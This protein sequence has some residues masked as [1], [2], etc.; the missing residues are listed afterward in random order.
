MQLSRERITQA[1][2]ELL[3][4][5]GLA[6]VSMRRVASS[7]GVAPGALYWHI[8]NKQ[9]LLA[10]LAEHIVRPLMSDPVAD[11]AE[12]S[13]ALREAVLG[14][15][16]GAEVL[17]AAVSQPDAE[18]CAQLSELFI[19]SVR[20]YSGEGSSSSEMRA[21]ALGL[22][23]LTLGDAAVHQASTQLAEAT[24][25]VSDT[26]ED[27]SAQMHAAAVKFLLDGLALHS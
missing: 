12:L 13:R 9:E 4:G 10:S 19:A 20:E 22:L 7:L 17:V 1:A 5:Y 26:Y 18:V 27:D 21:V 16:D 6:D 25:S 3:S 23:H 11:P 15:R 8:A 2:L 14:I 24:G